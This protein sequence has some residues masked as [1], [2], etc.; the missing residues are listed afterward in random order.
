MAGGSKPSSPPTPPPNPF[1]DEMAA[2]ARNQW[3]INK[4]LYGFSRSGTPVPDFLIKPILSQGN[5][6]IN[7]QISRA[8]ESLG[9]LAP[10][11]VKDKALAELAELGAIEQIGL[12]TGAEERLR[13]E[14]RAALTGGQE[15]VMQGLGAAA[16]DFNQRYSIALRQ[17]EV[18]QRRESSELGFIGT[19]A[20]IGGSIIGGS[21]GGPPGAIVGG[22][23]PGG[24]G[25]SG[26]PLGPPSLPPS[27]GGSG[28]GGLFPWNWGG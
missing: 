8:R 14:G 4:R 9:E 12:R 11:G 27:G 16:S 25:T 19:L 18:D 23:L 1:A 5:Q 28:L 10:G 20:S 13:R 21:I 2:I 22:S 6:A 7:Q 15:R 17:Q 26:G 24:Y 3:K